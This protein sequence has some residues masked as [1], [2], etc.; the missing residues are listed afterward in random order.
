MKTESK[1]TI[2]LIDDDVDLG[3]S[4]RDILIASSYEVNYQSGADEAL[5]LIESENFDAVV[6]DFEM[7]YLDGMELITRAQKFKPQLP[8]I[9]MTAF[10]STDRAIE[11]TRRGAFDYLLKP[12]E[13]P[14][15]L[16][17]VEKAVVSGR[18]SARKV[19][20]GGGSGGESC[21][22]K[23]VGTSK[24]IM[25]VFKEIGR[26]A[27]K[28][29]PVLIS[30]ETGTGKELVARAILQNGDRSDKPFIAVNC[31]A[32]PEGQLESELFGHERGAFSNA[33]NQKIGRFE[34][35]DGGT[36][37]LDEIGDISLDTQVKFLRVLQEQTFQRVGGKKNIQV[38]VRLITATHHDLKKRIHEGTFREDLYYRINTVEL[39]L[40][41]LRERVEDIPVLVD[42]FLDRTAREYRQGV[43]TITQKA[44]NLLKAEPW[45]GNVRQLE[46]TIRKVMLSAGERSIGPDLI[47]AALAE[48]GGSVIPGGV[49][50]KSA[51]G[52]FSEHIYDVLLAA[53][54]G[55]L[56]GR[57]AF[58]VLLED[59]EK[60]L[61]RQAVEL[62][63]GNQSAMAKWLGV[64]RLTVRDKLDRFELFPKREKPAAKKA[65]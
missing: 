40:P 35:A 6:T 62:S 18:I 31:A 51:G 29:V 15:L 10:N 60:E 7:P 63:H 16:V 17:A 56:E 9:M 28:P 30:G 1:G 20:L 14:D 22:D 21:R 59:V 39:H 58:E 47:A 38:D 52:N 3:H 53:S 11:A 4:I 37:F 19:S 41:P 49:A 45:P 13:I 57:G 33:I 64:S 8:I 23:M 5:D 48:P 43:P 25:N 27:G 12:V 65:E 2:L 24:A 55:K 50:T 26:V 54:K 34:Q 36:L 61:Y 46:N 44:L 32:I 42:Y